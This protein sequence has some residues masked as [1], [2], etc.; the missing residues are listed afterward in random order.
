MRGLAEAED[1]AADIVVADG[2]AAKGRA[3]VAQLT[4]AGTH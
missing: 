1:D 4:I 2:K 3:V